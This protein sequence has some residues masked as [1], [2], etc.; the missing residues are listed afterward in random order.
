[1]SIDHAI[2]TILGGHPEV[3]L[4]FGGSATTPPENLEIGTVV[5]GTFSMFYEH[6][7]VSNVRIERLWDRSFPIDTGPFGSAGDLRDYFEGLGWEDYP[8]EGYGHISRPR[9]LALTGIQLRKREEGTL[10]VGNL[11]AEVRSYNTEVL[12]VGSFEYWGMTGMQTSDEALHRAHAWA[13]ETIPPEY[14]SRVPQ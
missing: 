6:V 3:Y 12:W 5:P 7:L 2:Q 10:A 9:E 8:Y 13:R 14:K 1:M 11:C 4:G